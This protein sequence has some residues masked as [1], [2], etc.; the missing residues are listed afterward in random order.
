MDST[1]K[2]MKYCGYHMSP[3]NAKVIFES[4]S[5]DSDHRNNHAIQSRLDSCFSN[6]KIAL[7]HV[8]NIA[9]FVNLQ[10]NDELP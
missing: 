1:N 9:Q 3:Y 2:W 4:I 8:A 5:S 7:D 10:C 6:T